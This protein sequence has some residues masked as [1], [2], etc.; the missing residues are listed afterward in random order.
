MVI[1]MDLRLIEPNEKYETSFYNLSVDYKNHNENK[2][3]IFQDSIHD[4]YI[5]YLEKINSMKTKKEDSNF[6]PETT[7]WLIDD[8]NE[9]LGIL[10]YRHYL[11]K[12]LEKEGGN[13]GY[14]V[15]PSK[16]RN[17]YATK[18]L[19]LFL[20]KIKQEEKKDLLITC[21]KNNIASTKVITKNSGILLNEDISEITGKKILRFK[22]TL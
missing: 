6:V 1:F 16:R 12:K 19:F 5:K 15:P 20:E 7:Y 13:I 11:N 14:D 3:Q 8:K 10:R 2:Y 18:M 9:I 21:D 22:I 4:N 17:G